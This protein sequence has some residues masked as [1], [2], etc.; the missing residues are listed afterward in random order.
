MS[1][2]SLVHR[3]LHTWTWLLFIFHFEVAQLGPKFL[4]PNFTLELKV[5]HNIIV[6]SKDLGQDLSFE[7]SNIFVEVLKVGFLALQ[8]KKSIFAEFH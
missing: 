7:G 8:R 2:S 4:H 5:L 1:V 3:L 6:F